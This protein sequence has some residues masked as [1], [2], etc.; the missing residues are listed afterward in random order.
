MIY[1]KE[2][3]D[4]MK[5][6]AGEKY[7]PSNGTEGE[8]FFS[9][10]CCHCAR[11]KSMREGD[12]LDECDD[13]EVCKIIAD[14][15]AYEVD[16]PRYPAEWQYEKDGQPCCIAFVRHGDQIHQPRCQHTVD[17]FATHNV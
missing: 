17:M 8:C 7:R 12:P 13:N 14:T 10:W 5:A 3:A 11:D 1:P 9:S 16:D 15:F 2:F 4:M 6:R